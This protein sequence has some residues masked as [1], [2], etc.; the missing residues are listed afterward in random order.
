MRLGDGG[1]PHLAQFR[2]PCSEKGDPARRVADKNPE[3]AGVPAEGSD[4]L[5]PVLP[6][7]ADSL[8]SAPPLQ[9]QLP[10]H[11]QTL[12]AAQRDGHR[13]WRATEILTPL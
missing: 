5:A 6:G 2:G 12:T 7:H 4:G 8:G 13:E 3:H 1:G 10:H 11:H 9:L